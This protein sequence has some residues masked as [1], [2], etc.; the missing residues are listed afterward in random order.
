MNT[1]FE[2]IIHKS[3]IEISP[4]LTCKEWVDGVQPIVHFFVEQRL[5]KISTVLRN[6]AERINSIIHIFLLIIFDYVSPE[7]VRNL[8]HGCLIFT[9]LNLCCS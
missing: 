2:S 6:N 7:G 9:A 1:A 5:K 3:R 8:D 4:D